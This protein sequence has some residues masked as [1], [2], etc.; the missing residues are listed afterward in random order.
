MQYTY[1]VRKYQ[2]HLRALETGRKPSLWQALLTC[3]TAIIY[4]I[5]IVLVLL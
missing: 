5:F 3:F 1:I 4:W 2:I